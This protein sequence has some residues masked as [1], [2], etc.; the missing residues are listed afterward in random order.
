[1]KRVLYK[2]SGEVLMGS[3]EYGQ[4]AVKICSIAKD[5]KAVYDSGVEVCITVGGG[6]IFRGI[7][8]AEAGIDRVTGDYIGMLATVMN[9][10][11]LQSAIENLGIDTRVMSGINISAMCEVYI[12]R[13]AMRHLSKGRIIIFAAGTGNPFFTTDTGAVLRAIE[14]NCDGVFKGTSVDGVYS[15]DPKK[16]PDATRYDA[17]SYEEVIGKNLKVMDI[18]AV[19]MARDNN[20]PIYIFSIKDKESPLSKILSGDSIYTKIS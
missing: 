2:I 4:D 5:I 10:L 20:M 18:S 13:K 8:C 12:R 1:M 19:S 11:A 17:V 16:N 3:R 7:K 6:N 15:A 9:A 14:M